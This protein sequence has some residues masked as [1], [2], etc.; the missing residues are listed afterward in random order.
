MS[1]ELI[2]DPLAFQRRCAELRRRGAL[3]FVPTMGALHDGHVA[4]VNA[5]RERDAATAVSIFVNPTQFGPQE[6]FARYPRQLA[7]DCAR[8]EHAGVRI[9]FAPAPEAMYLRGEATRIEVA[10]LSERLCGA[11]RPG[12]F[13]GVATVVM[14]LLQ[15]AQ[16]DRA[17]FG[18][19]DAAQ[20]AVIRRMVADCFVP[21]EL[22]VCPIVREPDGV[23]MSSRNAY[24]SPAERQAAR[25]LAASLRAIAVA[26]AAGERRAAELAGLGRAVVEA[27]PGL[28]LDYYAAV[29]GATLEPVE[30]AGPGT[31]FAVAAFAG[32][33]RL[34]DNAH[35]TGEGEFRL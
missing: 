22:V 4:L 19:K 9:V 25:A 35:V 12:H 13:R 16:P 3:G 17:Y 5:S 32:A 2:E 11:S 7:A 20:A 26:W 1:L 14:K 31:L 33:T 28:R 29:D 24:L 34:I 8:L 21:V 27:E 23:A 10:G 15:L 30:R 6:D 18:Q